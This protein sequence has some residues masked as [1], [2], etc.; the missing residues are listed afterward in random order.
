MK[1]IILLSII[2]FGFIHTEEWIYYS[3][4]EGVNRVNADGSENELVMEGVFMRDLSFDKSKLLVTANSTN[5][6]S[7]VDIESMNTQTVSFADI[8]PTNLHFTYDEN[9]IYFTDNYYDLYKY[10]FNDK[11]LKKFSNSFL[12]Y[13]IE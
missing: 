10:S 1:K 13:D 8:S 9:V 7:I 5:A 11:M 12:S 3:N 2:T 6:V 4:S